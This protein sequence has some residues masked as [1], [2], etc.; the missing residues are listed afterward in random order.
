MTY[1]PLVAP[2]LGEWRND[3]AVSALSAFA[4]SVPPCAFT[5]FES[6][7]PS[8]VFVTIDGI[9][10]FGAE[11]RRT[12]VYG[13]FALVLMPASRKD[14]L[15]FRFTWRLNEKTTSADGSGSPFANLM[16]LRSWKVNVFAPF[17]AL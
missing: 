1:G 7:M 11:E 2:E 4:A 17:D 16:F 15:P 5:S 8:D 6:T 3:A 10:G 13:P 9:A 12:T 14:G